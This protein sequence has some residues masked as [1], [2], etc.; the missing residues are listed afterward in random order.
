MSVSYDE[1]LEDGRI[2]KF[3]CAA[4]FSSIYG[5]Y[6][7]YNELH[8]PKE[9]HYFCTPNNL[10]AKKHITFYVKF[11]QT[12][13]N[14]ELFR[15]NVSKDHKQT[16]IFKLKSSTLPRSKSLLYLT[17]FRYL[18]EFPS[19]GI[20][21]FYENNKNVKDSEILFKNWQNHHYD[22]KNYLRSGHTLMDWTIPIVGVYGQYTTHKFDP[23]TVKELA[24]NINN[25]EVQR[26]QEHFLKNGGKPLTPK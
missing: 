20:I 15:V 12:F 13:L 5:S 26:V 25:P 14:K 17:A 8:R 22:A 16:L 18:E 7:D 24:E 10:L 11:L 9:I 19:R 2:N 6:Y 3:R 23:I 4:C 21:N 1:I